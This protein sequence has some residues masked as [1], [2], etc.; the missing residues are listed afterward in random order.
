[1]AADAAAGRHLGCGELVS[2]PREPV[3]AEYARK[4]ER[5]QRR[6][7]WRQ[8]ELHRHQA[9]QQRLVQETEAEWQAGKAQE[10]LRRA[11]LDGKRSRSPSRRARAEQQASHHEAVLSYELEQQ[12][13]A[14]RQAAF[15]D[16]VAARLEAQ[17]PGGR[18]ARGSAAAE[19]PLREEEKGMLSLPLRNQ[20]HGV[21]VRDAGGG[22]RELHDDQQFS[23]LTGEEARKNSDRAHVVR[24]E[25]ADAGQTA[26]GRS[27]QLAEWSGG[28]DHQGSGPD[29]SERPSSGGLDTSGRPGPDGSERPSSGGLDTGGRPD[30]GTSRGSASSDATGFSMASVKLPAGLVMSNFGPVCSDNIE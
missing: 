15:A 9:E 12:A 16:E 11:F 21:H 8:V 26:D 4:R 25:A 30:S 5:V 24:D 10:Q 20:F 13:A 19:R 3:L 29:G 28:G 27:E 14:R 17:L 22:V 2:A 23:K 1:V 6:G 7:E 18:L